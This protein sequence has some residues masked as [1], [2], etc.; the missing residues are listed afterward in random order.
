[1]SLSSNEFS[2]MMLKPDVPVLLSATFHDE[3]VITMALW[4]YHFLTIIIERLE[5]EVEWQTIEQQS[6]FGKL[7]CR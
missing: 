6:T 3:P 5:K 4:H 2:Q 7:I 1:M